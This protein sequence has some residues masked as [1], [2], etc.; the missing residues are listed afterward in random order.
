VSNH[1]P[2]VIPSKLACRWQVKGGR[3]A[4]C[5]LSPPPVP[6]A[7]HLARFSRDVGYHG[8]RPQA[9]GESHNS[10]RVPHVRPSVAR[11]SYY[12][13]LATTTYAAFSRRKPH[14][15]AQRHQPRQEI[16]DTW[17]GDPQ[18][19]YFALLARATCAA[20]LKESRMKSINTTGL[21]RKS[22]GKPLRKPFVPYP[23]PCSLGAQPRDL[24]YA[25]PRRKNSQGSEFTTWSSSIPRR[26]SSQ[27]LRSA[28]KPPCAP[29]LLRPLP[30]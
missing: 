24:Q 12:A 30:G 28:S 1:S 14:A 4:L 25:S 9:S 26:T 21:H 22:G 27:Q 2:L 20:L 23:M 17:A 16:R 19:S 10:T 18:I 3:N 5:A 7:P 11:I 6:G 8:S 29:P 15:I 13:A